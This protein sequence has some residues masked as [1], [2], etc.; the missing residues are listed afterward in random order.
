M[1]V[2]TNMKN[3]R[4]GLS[5][6]LEDYLEA[7]AYLKKGKGSAK[8]SDIGKFLRVKN[9]SVNAAVAS[10]VH[11]GLANHER[12]GAV[13]LTAKGRRLAEDVQNRHD[14]IYEFLYEI[15]GVDQVTAQT[16]ACRIEHLMSASTVK[17]LVKFVGKTRKE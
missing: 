4:T 17:K 2:L 15:L 14:A 7:I 3:A 1:L 11:K 10:L 16:E 8:V 13:V 6:S 12:Y 9:S 5:S